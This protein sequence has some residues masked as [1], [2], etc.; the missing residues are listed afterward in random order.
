MLNELDIPVTLE[1]MFEQFVGRSTAAW[2]EK[3]AGLLGR[4]V[5]EVFVH[6]DAVLRGI[7]WQPREMVRCGGGDEPR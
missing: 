1:N 2:L 4:P 7:Q 6:Q 5:P 3:G